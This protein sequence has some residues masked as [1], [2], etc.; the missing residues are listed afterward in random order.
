MT[1]DQIHTVQGAASQHLTSQQS[2]CARL[3]RGP[4]GAREQTEADAGP[5]AAGA[6]PPLLRRRLADPRLLFTDATWQDVR[7]SM[8]GCVTRLHA[9]EA[10]VHTAVL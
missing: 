5:H 3:Q 6:P 1:T 7:K 4:R 2:V 10:D 8:D 9:Q